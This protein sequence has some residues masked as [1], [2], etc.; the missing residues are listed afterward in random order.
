MSGTPAFNGALLRAKKAYNAQA[1]REGRPTLA[2]HD[3]EDAV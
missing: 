3:L 1:N 2:E